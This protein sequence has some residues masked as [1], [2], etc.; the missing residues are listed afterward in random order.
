MATAPTLTGIDGVLF[1]IDGVLTI[2]WEPIDGA[3]ATVEALKAAGIAVRYLTNTTTRSRSRVADALGRAGIPVEPDE[4]FTAPVATVAYLQH[5][6]PDAGCFLL[7]SGDVLE[8]FADIRLVEEDAD[9]VVVGGAGESFT[10]QRLNRAF[11]M[12]LDGAALVGMHRNLYWRTAS[13]FELDTGAYLAAL[14]QA[15][16]TT[17]AVLGKPSAEF[18]AEAVAGLGLDRDRICMV[19]DD[20]VNDVLAAQEHGLHATLVRTGK[21]R[22]DTLADAPGTPEHVIDSVADLPTLLGIG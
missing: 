9:V 15:S 5:H 17:A 10:Y 14:E 6:H 19:G 3:A 1:D 2:S 18:F 16:G 22:P 12:L 8:D 4:I 20:I 7:N 11:Q 21:Y 13:G